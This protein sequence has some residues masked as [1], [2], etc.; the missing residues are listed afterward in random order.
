M[1]WE[2]WVQGG[3]SE[4]S[5]RLVA[6][7]ETGHEWE[8]DREMTTGRIPTQRALGPTHAGDATS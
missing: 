5:F 6:W 1:G 2:F 4:L 3:N 7:L 8:R